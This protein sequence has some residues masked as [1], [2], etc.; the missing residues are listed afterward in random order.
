MNH[1]LCGFARRFLL[2]LRRIRATGLILTA[3]T[4]DPPR[5]FRLA[6]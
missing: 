1:S 2:T 3:V 6:P 5:T 4:E